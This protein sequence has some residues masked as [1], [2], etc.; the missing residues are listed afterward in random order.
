MAA[1]GYWADMFD[2]LV[3]CAGY[4]DGHF[5]PLLLPA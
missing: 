5:V 1:A 3:S 4:M 2:I